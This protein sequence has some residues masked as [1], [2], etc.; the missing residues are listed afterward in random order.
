MPESY[1]IDPKRKLVVC[2]V[3]GVLSNGDLREHYRRLA[4]D[5]EFDSTYAQIGD[6]REVTDF[7]VDSAMIEST[8]RTPVFAPHT[9]R[10]FVAPRGVAFGLARMFAAHS[11]ADGQN[12]E[13]FSNLEDAETW[14]GVE[15]SLP[16]HVGASH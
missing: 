6:L 4:A 8:A 15:S 9:K 1:E 13:V 3:W 11:V 7:T 10:A 5:P 16:H 12:L 2:R 14:L